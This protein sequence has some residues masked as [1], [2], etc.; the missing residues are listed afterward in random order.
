[1]ARAIAARI[2]FGSMSSY[3][4]P[5]AAAKAGA[6]IGAGAAG[7]GGATGGAARAASMS[8]RSIRPSGPLPVI[9]ARSRPYS[10][11]SRRAS[12]EA[13]T[14]PAGAAGGASGAGASTAAAPLLAGAAVSVA[15]AALIVMLSAARST[16]SPGWATTAMGCPT[17]TSSPAWATIVCRMP[18]SKFS[19]SMVT[20]SVS[21][22]A[23]FSPRLTASPSCLSQRTILP[24]SMSKPILG[25]IRVLAIVRSQPLGEVS[26][27]RLAVNGA[28]P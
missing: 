4:G 6:G 2:R 5:V 15:G 1:M 17:G 10:A 24:C 23:T 3:S 11:A 16:A 22:S 9:L 18:S 21:I 28:L 14:R 19:T 20:F 26:G 8:R 27:T 12:G 7:G 25:I 13:R